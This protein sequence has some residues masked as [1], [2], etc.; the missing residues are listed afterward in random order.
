MKPIVAL[1]LSSSAAVSLSKWE[2][3]D[4]NGDLHSSFMHYD[5]E[6]Q[7]WRSPLPGSYNEDYVQIAGEE[8]KDDSEVVMHTVIGGT[9]DPADDD[10]TAAQEG[11]SAN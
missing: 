1:L 7:L 6:N 11:F 10:I 9:I 3:Q 5:K 2:T 4:K 8:D